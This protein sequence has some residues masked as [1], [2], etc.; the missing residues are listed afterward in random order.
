MKIASSQ[1]GLT[2]PDLADQTSIAQPA[3]NDID[4]FSAQLKEEPKV[5]KVSAP[6]QTTNFLSGLASTL[7][8]NERERKETYQDLQKASRSSNLLEF[9]QANAALSNYY[10]ENL[11]NAKIVAKGVQSIDKLTNLQ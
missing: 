8:N 9:S 4:F 6:A 10:I 7:N 1:S 3:Q 2:Q 5:E 11:M